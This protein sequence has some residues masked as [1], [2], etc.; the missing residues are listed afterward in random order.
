MVLDKYDVAK[1]RRH[2]RRFREVLANP[3]LT[4]DS[5]SIGTGGPVVSVTGGKQGKGG[6]QSKGKGKL[7][8]GVKGDKVGSGLGAES[9]E[10]V[11]ARLL[12]LQ[13]KMPQLD[14]SAS[15]SPASATA[16]LARFYPSLSLTP[17]VNTTGP[18]AATV[19][20]TPLPS[21][22]RSIVMSGYNPPP[23]HRRLLGDLFYLEVGDAAPCLE[24]RS[25]G[26]GPKVSREC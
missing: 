26:L 13:M 7:V 14:F 21:C 9:K 12:D 10:D 6:K 4:L 24:H 15:A 1:A 2:I 19:S 16:L 22:L 20:P 8:K 18:S 3:P 5:D 17:D 11:I 25:R 23:P